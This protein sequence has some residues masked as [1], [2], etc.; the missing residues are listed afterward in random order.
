MMEEEDIVMVEAL[1]AV[2]AHRAVD[3]SWWSVNMA[4]F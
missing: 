1:D 3:R 2:V 4:R